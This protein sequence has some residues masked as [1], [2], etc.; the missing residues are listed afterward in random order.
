MYLLYKN[1][2]PLHPGAHVGFLLV[3]PVVLAATLA[4]AF[5]GY[6][7][8]M[9][10]Y[11]AILCVLPVLYRLSPFHPLA[12]F[13]GPVFARMS[14]LYFTYLVA[15]GDSYLVVRKL[16]QKYGEVVRIG[17]PSTQYL[18]DH[19]LLLLCRSQ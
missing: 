9:L 10:Y 8:V 16:H 1:F 19:V 12:A 17:K 5:L 4:E 7:Q 14:K 11:W 2:E 6:V 15:Q 3:V 18:R 13:P